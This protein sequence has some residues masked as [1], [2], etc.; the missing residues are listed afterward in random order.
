[1]LKNCT[2]KHWLQES[3]T[4]W[5]PEEERE[6]HE[7]LRFGTDPDCVI[8]IQTDKKLYLPCLILEYKFD[9]EPKDW[10][11]LVEYMI[12]TEACYGSPVYGVLG[13][14]K[15][16]RFFKY[17][18]KDEEE[19]GVLSASKNMNFDLYKPSYREKGI[20]KIIAGLVF[21]SYL[22]WQETLKSL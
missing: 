13:D 8:A 7:S 6:K 2:F 12:I 17:T 16:I 4:S 11:Q 19:I 9:Y 3:F 10:D 18:R 15:N 20:Y 21:R 1:M 14:K 5:I 22:E